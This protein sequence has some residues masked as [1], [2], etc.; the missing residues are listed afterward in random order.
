MYYDINL[1]FGIY[2]IKY[3]L[4]STLIKLKICQKSK[5][6]QLIKNK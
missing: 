3:N 1:I 5:N 2:L 6:G 4:Q